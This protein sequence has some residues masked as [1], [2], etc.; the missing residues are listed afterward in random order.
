MTNIKPRLTQVQEFTVTGISTRTNNIDE[1]NPEKA[2]L[3]QLW[4]Q[5]FTQVLSKLVPIPDNTQ[6][7]YGVYAD[8][9]SD[10]SGCYT[11]M[12]GM[13]CSQSM[14]SPIYHSISV[15]PGD[16][17]VFEN[18][19]KNPEAIIETWQAIWK[20]FECPSTLEQ[21]A[22]ATDFECY[23]SPEEHAVFIGMK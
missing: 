2:R 7:I 15:R 19:G 23:T 5:F 9:D 14:L 12:A 11:V 16:Y 17:L 1:F 18:R 21:R 10:S 6:R 3:P 13:D 4:E 20:Y 22:Y 8:Y